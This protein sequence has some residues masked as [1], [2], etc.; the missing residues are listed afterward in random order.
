M[1]CV[2]FLFIWPDS[3]ASHSVLFPHPLSNCLLPIS[4]RA[5][6]PL[7][8]FTVFLCVLAWLA[9]QNGIMRCYWEIL[10]SRLS[11]M[12]CRFVSWWKYLSSFTK[13]CTFYALFRFFCNLV[14]VLRLKK[15]FRW[16]SAEIWAISIDRSMKTSAKVQYKDV[17]KS[18]NVNRVL[19]E[20]KELS[21]THL[22]S[23]W[24]KICRKAKKKE[25][26]RNGKEKR[27]NRSTIC[28]SFAFS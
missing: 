12:C 20:D 6:V 15:G 9:G 4:P 24:L 3:L 7:P 1:V 23:I 18:A 13:V 10:G 17:G 26:R 11:F 14:V 21:A 22:T 25:R 8:P 16:Y 5:T 2:L 28:C 27:R 19:R